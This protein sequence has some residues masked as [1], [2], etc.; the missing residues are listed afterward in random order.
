MPEPQDVGVPSPDILLEVRAT[1]VPGDLAPRFLAAEKFK[2][3]ADE[4]ASSI[5]AIAESF[6]SRLQP[7]LNSN[8]A[9]AWHIETMEIQFSVA[10]QA[11]AGVVISRTSAGATFSAKVVL[12][13]HSSEQP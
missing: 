4:I 8:R 7:S 11:E 10:V 12:Q 2:A 1:S 3:R 13:S 5:S 6:R 9:D